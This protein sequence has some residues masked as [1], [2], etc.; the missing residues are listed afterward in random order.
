M[1]GF[2]SFVPIT[3]VLKLNRKV[4]FQQDF[5]LRN[6]YLATQ[7]SYLYTS[8]KNGLSQGLSVILT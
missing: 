1:T 7:S 2:C 4:S 3:I 6:I 5:F 8:K